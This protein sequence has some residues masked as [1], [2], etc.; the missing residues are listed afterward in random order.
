MSFK[1]HEK[2]LLGPDKQTVKQT[3]YT[4]EFFHWNQITLKYKIKQ[5]INGL[6][7][8]ILHKNKKFCITIKSYKAELGYLDHPF[9]NRFFSLIV[10]VN[11]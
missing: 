9:K 4:H 2:N 3:I 11:P 5:V 10:R 1:R 7:V 6:L 8:W